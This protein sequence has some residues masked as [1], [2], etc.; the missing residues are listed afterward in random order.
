VPT[1]TTD[2][3]TQAAE[4]YAATLCKAFGR[5]LRRLRRAKELSQDALGVPQTTVS[6]IEHGNSNA[7]ILTMA[8]LAL[9]VG[10]DVAAM[11]RETQPEGIR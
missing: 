7:N 2:N 5:S 6:N 3:R 4:E 1:E 11:L 8:R 10:G 9:A